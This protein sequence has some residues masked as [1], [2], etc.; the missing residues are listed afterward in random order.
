MT[1]KEAMIYQLRNLKGKPLKQK[2]EHIITYFGLPILA[3]VAILGIAVS[4]I[5]NLATTKD[6]AL[7]VTCINAYTK[8]DQAE[9]YMQEFARQANI[10]LDQYTVRFSTNTVISDDDLMASYESVQALLAQIAAQSIDVMVSD[11]QTL[12]RYMYQE[13]FVNLT[14]VLNPEQQAQY[15][16]YFLYMDSAI[17]KELEKFPER[18]IEFPDP[19]KPELMAEP[20]AV[21]LLL[22]E[23]GPLQ[24]LCYP[25]TPDKVAVGILANSPNSSNALAFLDYILK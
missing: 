11:P 13:A 12:S 4:Y 14:Q 21:A 5:V 7:T 1:S 18:I 23:T 6:S 2:L 10:D 3:V 25:H 20:V 24:Q 17:L 9:A 22:P 16:Q 15:A 19:A 8:Y